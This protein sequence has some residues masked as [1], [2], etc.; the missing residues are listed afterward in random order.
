MFKQR[1][2]ARL[3][4]TATTNTKIVDCEPVRSR[5]EEH[6]FSTVL[7]NIAILTYDHHSPDAT[8][9]FLEENIQE[10]NYKEDPLSKLFTTSVSN[11]PTQPDKFVTHNL[12][13]TDHQVPDPTLKELRKKK[14]YFNPI[15][16]TTF[17]E[18]SFH[19]NAHALVQ[20]PYSPLPSR[21]PFL[22]R[23]TLKIW[24][25]LA[26]NN[27]YTLLSSIM[28]LQSV[29]GIRPD[30]V[31]ADKGDAAKKIRKGMPL[32]AKV[33][34]TGSDMYLFLDKL[35]QCALPRIQ[36]DWAGINPVGDGKGS[37]S[38]I[39]PAQALSY[40][41]DIEPH[42]DM[43][44]RLV[45]TEITFQCNEIDDA[46]TVLLLSAF[47]VPMADNVEKEEEVEVAV[48][49]KWDRLKEAKSREERK[50]LAALIAKEKDGEGKS[51]EARPQKTV[52]KK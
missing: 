15:D 26:V 2:L 32:G 40:F 42:F 7:P 6:Y 28:A 47:Q 34:L 10:W 9:K 18:K 5:L 46:K 3:M 12:L 25:E 38:F 1:K 19:P 52:K 21:L 14:K 30:P 27:K 16:Y 39:L 13:S 31:F 33:E 44:P 48:T 43:Y 22:K 49:N 35:V 51:K 37:L 20:K 29:T 23:I 11:L 36:D 45:D 41:P 8:L 50:A 24:D 4:S 17:K